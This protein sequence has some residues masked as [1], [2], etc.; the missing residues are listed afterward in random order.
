MAG[1]RVAWLVRVVGGME[2][3]KEEEEAVEE[4]MGSGLLQGG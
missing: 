3:G 1:T 2:E 4:K